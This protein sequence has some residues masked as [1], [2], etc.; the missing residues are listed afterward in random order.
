MLTVCL[1]VRSEDRER[2]ALL[3]AVLGGRHAG[4]VKLIH[5]RKVE[6]LAHA[7]SLHFMHCNFGAYS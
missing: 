1:V 3:P 7:I 6:N 2:L 5:D 4:W